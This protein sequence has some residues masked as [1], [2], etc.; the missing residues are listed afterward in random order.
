LAFESAP[1]LFPAE[2]PI[3][4]VFA[5]LALLALFVA[6]ASHLGLLFAMWRRVPA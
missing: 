3:G 4:V 6:S 2:R 5:A 1:V